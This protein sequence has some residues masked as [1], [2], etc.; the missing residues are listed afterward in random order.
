MLQEAFYL[1]DIA[2]ACHPMAEAHGFS[3]PRAVNTR[4]PVSSESIRLT[5]FMSAGYIFGTNPSSV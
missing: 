4:I 3:R 1:N 5:V 2:A